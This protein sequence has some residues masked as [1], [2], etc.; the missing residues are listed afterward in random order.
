MIIVLEDRFVTSL[1]IGKKKKKKKKKHLT[2]SPSFDV[3]MAF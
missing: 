3:T 1:P 2:S